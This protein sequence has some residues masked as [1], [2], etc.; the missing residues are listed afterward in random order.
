MPWGGDR[1]ADLGLL[2]QLSRGGASLLGGVDNGKCKEV[3]HVNEEAEIKR[4]W[5]P[6]KWGCRDGPENVLCRRGNVLS[7]YPKEISLQRKLGWAVI[8]VLVRKAYMYQAGC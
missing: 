5:W 8:S 1:E 6:Y 4:K 7:S 3:V 2:C